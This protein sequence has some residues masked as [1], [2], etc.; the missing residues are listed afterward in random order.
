MLRGHSTSTERLIQQQI[1]QRLNR[2]QGSVSSTNQ[3]KIMQ[4]VPQLETGGV[5]RGTL[6]IGQALVRAGHESLVVS[7]G[8][9]LVEP[10]A[11]AGSRHFELQVWKKSP[12][13]LFTV[14]K[15]RRLILN[16]KPDI[17]HARSRIPAWVTRLALKT[18]PAQKRP[19]F[20]TTA[21][22]MNRVSRYSRVMVSGDHVIAVSNTTRDYLLKGYPDLNA[23]RV[24]VIH[25]G[26]CEEA[27]PY[28]Y[29][30][31]K[32][33]LRQWYE[34]YPQLRGRFTVCVSGRLTRLKGHMDLL[35]ALVKLNERNVKVFAV[36]AGGADK[37]RASY[38]GEL[39]QRIEELGLSDQVVLTGHRSDIRDVL[40]ACDVTISTT[41][42]P[43]ESFGRSVLE[44]VRLG[45]ITLG[46]DHGGVGEVLATAY[47]DGRVP[48]RNID[49]LADRIEM[50]FNGRLK[51]PENHLAFPL[52]DMESKTLALYQR[53]KTESASRSE[54]SGDASHRQRTAA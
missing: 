53:L 39:K 34:T 18:L 51:P 25:R 20:L 23:E 48:L 29:Q 11:G 27:F 9:R 19:V 15:L 13:T 26:V 44:S 33:W 54:N 30:P 49:A 12:A 14:P 50:A 4:L 46:Y 5:E 38:F 36:I 41:Y 2:R 42:H 47:P 22:G 28:G 24:T 32:E 52:A 40:S 31:E 37:R 21:H 1:P 7:G 45:K 16:E 43:P 35:A 8:G 3:L 6:E 17:V 10:L